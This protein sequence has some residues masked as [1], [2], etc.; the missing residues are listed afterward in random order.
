MVQRRKEVFL[1]AALL[2]G[3][4]CVLSA[5]DSKSTPSASKRIEFSRDIQPLLERRCIVCHGSRQQ[6]GGLRL[7]Q[8]DD[9]L[10]GGKSGPV[11]RP[12]HSADSRL[13][14]LVSG[15]EGKLVMPP[16]GERLNAAEIRMLR[17][18][19]DQGA[20]WPNT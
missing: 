2:C 18:W 15:A 7:D 8:K 4:P 11:I 14:R 19:I 1:F 9:A 17:A 5:A 3:I 13:I 6:M 20:N 10:R 12:G 16:V